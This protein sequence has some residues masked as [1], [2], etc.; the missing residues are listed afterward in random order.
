MTGRAAMPSSATVFRK[1]RMDKS[2]PTSRSSCADSDHRP[3][4][5]Q[6]PRGRRRAKLGRSVG[7]GGGRPARRT[8][9]SLLPAASRAAGVA[10][11]IGVSSQEFARAML[12][13]SHGSQ[14]LRATCHTVGAR[15]RAAIRGQRSTVGCKSASA[16]CRIDRS[17]CSASPSSVSSSG[18]AGR[19]L[20]QGATGRS[21]RQ[22]TADHSFCA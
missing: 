14:E 17:G 3:A 5:G 11:L 1:P 19:V 2:S 7:S 22:D 20:R 4:A 10:R 18:N 16:A 9:G 12:A 8:Q 13:G 21:A 6:Q 15:G